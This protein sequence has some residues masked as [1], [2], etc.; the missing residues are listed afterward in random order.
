M[1]FSA[2]GNSGTRAMRSTRIAIYLVVVILAASTS[3]Q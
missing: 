3:S 2:G 1:R